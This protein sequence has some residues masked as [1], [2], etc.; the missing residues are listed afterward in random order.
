MKYNNKWND[1]ISSTNVF[2]RQAAIGIIIVLGPFNYL[3]N[4]TYAM[5]IPTLLM[6]NII[7]LKIPTVGRLFPA[8]LDKVCV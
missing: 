7:I 4:E 5:L 1:K 3:L 2:I 6:E 8:I